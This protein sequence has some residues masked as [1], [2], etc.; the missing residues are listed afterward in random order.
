MEIF[1]VN[2]DG[3]VDEEDYRAIMQPHQS[4]AQG[5]L[6]RTDPR[7]VILDI[8]NTFRGLEFD[9]VSGEWKRHEGSEPLMNEKGINAIMP[10]VRSLVN[11]NS[12]LSNFDDEGRDLVVITSDAIHDLLEENWKEYGIRKSQLSSV[13]SVFLNMAVPCVKRG[14]RGL[15]LNRASKVTNENISYLRDLRG[16]DGRGFGDG[17]RRRKFLGIF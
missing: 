11:D 4:D 15:T 14:Y 1:D 13:I 7:V 8:K 5:L 10:L 12:V 3:K 16:D 17:G 6:D 2:G 9:E